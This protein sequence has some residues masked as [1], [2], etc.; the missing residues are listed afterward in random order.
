MQKHVVIFA[1]TDSVRV[2][3]AYVG[4]FSG[5]GVYEVFYMGLASKLVACLY[6]INVA[7]FQFY[8]IDPFVG[9]DRGNIYVV[10]VPSFKVSASV[11][12]L[13]SFMRY[14]FLFIE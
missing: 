1:A 6:Y 3:I 9:V 7:A 13:I 5:V 10:T 8:C 12:P 2:S 11:V 4:K 14:C